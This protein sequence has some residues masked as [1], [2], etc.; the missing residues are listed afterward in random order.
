MYE[1]KY[2]YLRMGKSKVIALDFKKKQELDVDYIGEQK[3][4]MTKEE[5]MVITAF[6]QSRK[7]ANKTKKM[8]RRADCKSC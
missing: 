4:P 5:Q 2:V 1:R 6:I 3:Q 8:I 7:S